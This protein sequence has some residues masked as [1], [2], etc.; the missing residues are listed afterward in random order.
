MVIVL[1]DL[2][3]VVHMAIILLVI[4][5]TGRYPEYALHIAIWWTV[6]VYIS[7][8]IASG[9][10]PFTRLSNYL[11]RL[12]GHPKKNVSIVDWMLTFMPSPYAEIVFT[13]SLLCA[14]T[15]GTCRVF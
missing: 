2:V 12:A 6:I 14:G 13:Y 4:F 5:A 7:N 3:Q 10:C 11:F 8:R 1:A 15:L 9:K